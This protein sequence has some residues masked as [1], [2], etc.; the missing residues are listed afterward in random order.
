MTYDRARR[1][2]TF[3]V[4]SLFLVASA[5]WG[6]FA[7]VNQYF[8]S[9]SQTLRPKVVTDRTS[10]TVPVNLPAATVSKRTKSSSG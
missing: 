2:V 1:R 4:V 6:L 8:D 9:R 10:L 3:A 5:L 7:V